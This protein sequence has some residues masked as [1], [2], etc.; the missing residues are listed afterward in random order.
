[1]IDSIEFNMFS[2]TDY[3]VVFDSIQMVALILGGNEESVV[4]IATGAQMTT[5]MFRCL[6]MV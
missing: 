3:L 5:C 6:T 1:M 2:T 4:A